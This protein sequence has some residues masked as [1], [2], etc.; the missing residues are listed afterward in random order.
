MVGATQHRK[1]AS[2]QQASPVITTARV[3]R[4]P[5]EWQAVQGR[6]PWWLFGAVVAGAAMLAAWVKVYQHVRQ[7]TQAERDALMAVAPAKLQPWRPSWPVDTRAFEKLDLEA[8]HGELMPQWVQSLELDDGFNR[9]REED[10]FIELQQAVA[11]DAN[12]RDL[13]IEL[14][15]NASLGPHAYRREIGRLVDGWNRYMEQRR[16]RWFLLHHIEATA[17]GGRLLML[18]YRVVADAPVRVGEASYRAR[19]LQRADRLP[20]MEA[21]L[22]RAGPDNGAVIVSNS[23]ADFAIDRLWPLFDEQAPGMNTPVDRSFAPWLRNEAQ[24]AIGAQAV[25]IL[26]QTAPARQAMTRTL[27]SIAKR[28]VCGRAFVVPQLAWNGLSL[29]QQRELAAAVAHNERKRCSRVTR[30]EAELLLD[31]TRELTSAQG[32]S[33]ALSRLHGWLARAVTVHEARHLA[34]DAMS[35]GDE[36]TPPCPQCPPGLDRDDRAELSAYLS[37]M[38]NPNVGYVSMYQACGLQGVGAGAV[39][40]AQALELVAPEGCDGHPPHNLYAMAQTAHHKLFGPSEQAN[41]QALPESLSLGPQRT[42][43]TWE[44]PPMEPLAVLLRV[45]PARDHTSWPG[46]RWSPMALSFDSTL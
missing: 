30:S 5:A 24:R 44:Q 41:L 13:V 3:P 7:P 29:Q 40:L 33:E 25:Q 14:R 2:F 27:E 21:F 23:T 22:G 46:A 37:A 12:L 34:D 43:V 20:L 17:R 28:K 26:A 9:G 8:I 31:K 11:P 35:A 16:A 15:E 39:A 42:A 18:G 36:R 1:R 6:R 4:T 19:W 38:G 10:R 32:L 45:L